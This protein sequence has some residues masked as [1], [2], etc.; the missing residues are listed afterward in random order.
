[1]YLAEVHESR[2]IHLQNPINPSIPWYKKSNNNSYH[3]GLISIQNKEDFG[4]SRKVISKSYKYRIYYS[5]VETAGIEE[6]YRYFS[7]SLITPNSQKI[8]NLP[9]MSLYA[10][11]CHYVRLFPKM[12]TYWVTV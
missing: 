4:N 6:T 2:I 7:N 12:V 8:K 9:I 3:I 5:L 11:M 1:M 10:I